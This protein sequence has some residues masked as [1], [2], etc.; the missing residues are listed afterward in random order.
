VTSLFESWKSSVLAK[1]GSA[2]IK[3]MR[4]DG[5]PYPDES[6]DCPEGLLIIDVQLNLII[7]SAAITVCAGEIFFV[8]VGV[9][10]ALASGSIGTLVIFDT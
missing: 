3:V 8:P 7:G 9:A 4:M 5:R 2:N 6:H 10:H 1:V